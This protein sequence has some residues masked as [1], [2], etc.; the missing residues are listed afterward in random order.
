MYLAKFIGSNHDCSHRKEFLPRIRPSPS[1]Q[2]YVLPPITQ[3]HSMK[4]ILRDTLPHRTSTANP[5]LHHLQQLIHIVRPTPL[6]MLND[7]HTPIHLRFLHQFAIRPH[8]LLTIRLSELIAN[9]RRRMQTRERN[10]L[11]AI[12]QLAQTLDICLLLGVHGVHALGKLLGLLEIWE[13]TLH[14]NGVRVWT[15]RDCA[16]DGAFAAALESVVSL[17][18]AWGVPVPWDVNTGDALG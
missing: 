9:Q 8:P 5:T 6:L 4:L 2:S 11:P 15:V 7:I 12:A 16:V 14:P 18:C 3:Q 13:F 10:E 17:S 1:S